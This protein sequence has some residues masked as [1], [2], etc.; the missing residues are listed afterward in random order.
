MRFV[1]LGPPGAGK[2]SLAAIIK[3]QLSVVHLSTGDML[4]E[5]IKKNSPLGLE[6][7]SLIEKGSLV[8]DDI[9]TKL[10]KSKVVDD[11]SISAKSYMLDG[12]PRTV[13][14]AQ[15]LDNMLKLVSKP[16]DFVVNMEAHL[17][18]ILERLAGRRVC[19]KCG[20][21]Y[22]LTNKRPKVTGIC[23]ACAGE[24][25]QRSDDNE[26]TIKKRMDVY[27]TSTQPII[28]YYAKQGKVRILNGNLDT[29]DLFKQF[30][31]VTR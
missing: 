2:G 24:L 26:E 20:E 31:T 15:D 16:L 8:S 21:I 25:Y 30:L 22:H 4:R 13:T 6:I 19:R 3:E 18:L 27:M 28:D 17:D 12:Y 7:K 1:L 11:L 23:D 14:Q 10:I 9:V 5:E 29:A